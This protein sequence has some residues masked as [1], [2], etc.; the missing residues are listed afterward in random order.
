MALDT[1]LTASDPTRRE[2]LLESLV[3]ILDGSSAV[4]AADICTS[5][6]VIAVGKRVAYVPGATVLHDGR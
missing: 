3:C 2:I 4:V 6:V 5:Q 1:N